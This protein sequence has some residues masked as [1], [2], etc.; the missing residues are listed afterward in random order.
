MTFSA[1]EIVSSIVSAF[2]GILTGCASAIVTLFQVLFQNATT[3]EGVT[4][5]SGISTLGIWT[6][7]FIGIG[8][9]MALL[10]RVSGKVLNK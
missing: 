5:Y 2:Q 9:A 10:R 8:A 1:A 6:L 3:V 4:T 7:A